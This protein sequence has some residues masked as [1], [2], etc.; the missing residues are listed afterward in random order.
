MG[1]GRYVIDTGSGGI[2]L[3]LPPEV[4][5]AFQADT[6]SGSISVDLDGVELGRKQRREAR[7]TVGDGDSRVRLSTGSGSIRI[8]QAR[9]R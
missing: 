9:S 4:S 5:A 8:S 6:G 3:R 1:Q 2:R 7:F